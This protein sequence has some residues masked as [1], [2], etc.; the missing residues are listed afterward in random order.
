LVFYQEDISN[1]TILREDCT[2]IS[3]IHSE[4]KTRNYDVSTVFML[5][6]SGLHLC[7]RRHSSPGLSQAPSQRCA[8]NFEQLSASIIKIEESQIFRR[9]NKPLDHR[10]RGSERRL[11]YSFSQVII[12]LLLEV[13]QGPF[14]LWNLLANVTHKMACKLWH[15]ALGGQRSVLE[16]VLS[17]DSF[18]VALVLPLT[19]LKHNVVPDAAP[20]ET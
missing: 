12:I 4:V 20:A 11:Y 14:G 10:Y 13:F 17:I 3:F 9:G 8:S 15:G 2:D 16:V 6:Y 19:F 18:S 5:R 1:L 7:A